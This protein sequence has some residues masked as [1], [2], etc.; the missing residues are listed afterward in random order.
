MAYWSW[1]ITQVLQ[2]L[3]WKVDTIMADLSAL[4]AAATQ[5]QSDIASA[6]EL[7]NSLKA[8]VDSGGG[9]SQADLDAV[10]ATLSGANAT[11]ES[12]VSTDTPSA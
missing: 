11:L 7:L 9:V 4:Q 3:E 5:T 10:T 8:T 1:D 12:A 6:I 2:R